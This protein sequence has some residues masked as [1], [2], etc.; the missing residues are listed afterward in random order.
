MRKSLECRQAHQV[1][2]VYDHDTCCRFL[3]WFGSLCWR[4]YRA[5]TSLSLGAPGLRWCRCRFLWFPDPLQVIIIERLMHSLSM[6]SLEILVPAGGRLWDP[7]RRPI[8]C[9]SQFYSSSHFLDCL[10]HTCPF[11]LL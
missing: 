11:R 9:L 10:F 3:V 6:G 8:T 7:C 1:V 2:N 5:R 4:S